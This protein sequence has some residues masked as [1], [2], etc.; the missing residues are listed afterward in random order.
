MNSIESP[1]VFFFC[2][3]FVNGKPFGLRNTADG[4]GKY[5]Y[6]P[7]TQ[8]GYFEGDISLDSFRSMR[9]HQ[10]YRWPKNTLIYEFA[11]TAPYA[12]DQHERN[13]VESAMQHLVN[14]INQKGKCITIRK[15]IPEDGKFYSRVRIMR[16]GGCH[17]QVGRVNEGWQTLSLDRGCTGR[18]TVMH[19]TMHSLGLWHEQSRLDRDD[20]V[21]IV[22]ENINP[23]V[24]S[25]FNKARDMDIDNLNT[26]YDYNSLM[27]YGRKWWSKNGRDTIV[28]KDPTAQIGVRSEPS[29]WDIRK[30]RILYGCD[31]KPTV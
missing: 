18:G 22:Y 2:I 8:E 20:Y 17:S 29:E 26:P 24:W 19:E 13:Q 27:H 21:T 28:P 4:T 11:E 25:Q 16:S 5:I 3:C 9:K 23:G 10:W 14:V 12:L 7:E 15:A 30:I 31:P 1:L 6:N